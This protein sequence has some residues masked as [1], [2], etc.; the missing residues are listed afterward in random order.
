MPDDTDMTDW[1]PGQ[2]PPWLDAYGPAAVDDSFAA[3]PG[4]PVQQ[5]AVPALAPKPA[6]A[7]PVDSS[8]AGA[9][10]SVEPPWLAAMQPPSATP[11][12][13]PPTGAAETGDQIRGR[14][15]VDPNASLADRQQAFA[16]M[17]PQ[18][19][20]AL[21][22]NADPNQLAAIATSTM[23]QEDLA[24]IAIRHQQAQI[25]AQSAQQLTLA[26]K[27]DE[28]ARTNM[29][30]YQASV[31]RANAATEQLSMDAQKLSQEKIDPNE[32]GVGHFIASVLTSA[33][34]GAFSKYSGGRNL[35]LEEFD[36][37]TEQ[38]IAAQKADL[39]NQWQGIGLKRNLIGEQLQRS[40]DMYRAQETYRIGQYDRATAELQTKMQDYDPQGTTAL[41]AAGT[42]QQLQVARQ[43]ALLKFN[44]EQQK[45][46]LA[47]F[48]EKE[49]ARHNKADESIA[50]AKE[51]REGAAAKATGQV[52]QP[53]ELQA[54]H[55]GMQVPP[56]AMSLKDYG[57]WLERQQ[58][59]IA[60]GKEGTEAEAARNAGTIRNPVTK[61]PLQNPSDPSKTLVFPAEKAI[62]TNE[63]IASTQS[64]I[65]NLSAARRALDA[66]P[67]TFDRKEWARI[68]SNIAQ[69]FPQLAKIYGEKYSAR[70]EEALK[71]VLNLD[72]DSYRKRVTDKGIGK[73]TID[74]TIDTLI[75][76]GNT[77]IGTKL[78]FDA[79]KTP[80]FLDTSRPAESPKTDTDKAVGKLA[81]ATSA[82]W[83]SEDH[84]IQ[85]MREAGGNPATAGRLLLD[86]GINVK[87][88]KFQSD[89]K[90]VEATNVPI[91]KLRLLDDL[92][93]KAINGKTE[94]DQ[95]K[96]AAAISEIASSDDGD[97][98]DLARSLATSI[99][100]ERIK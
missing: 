22:N 33:V 24:T 28:D 77:N 21:V 39:A 78:G 98:G 16:G 68:Q 26:Q 41:R 38:R 51:G 80:L 69:S 6:A 31:Q 43:Q 48:K 76:N 91:S 4:A 56:L 96:A 46:D 25:H 95:L 79:D 32:H 34:G 94:D 81:S 15:A 11:T 10:Q 86:Y 3:T 29:M 30:A 35:A 44:Q 88:P 47:I 36:K 13:P 93:D 82:E 5:D 49:I 53:A 72:Y 12:P 58:K 64:A 65:D 92:H 23:S 55:P 42:I 75:R 7:P 17:S 71:D 60:L 19:R 9:P 99:P 89:L 97:L 8:I 63:Q 52:F 62:E 73:A 20:T 18:E 59:G 70:T 66:D 14:V 2:Q 87:D 37:K 45:N 100:T 83:T 54:L 57:G 90:R 74:N 84:A 85:K 27:A 67:S 50:W 40:G 61:Q 1:A